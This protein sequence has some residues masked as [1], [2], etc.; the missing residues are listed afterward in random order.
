MNGYNEARIQRTQTWVYIVHKRDEAR[1]VHRIHVVGLLKCQRDEFIHNLGNSGELLKMM[2][3][4]NH[5]IKGR[6]E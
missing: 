2:G 6:Q 3:Q 4:K 1:K 5:W